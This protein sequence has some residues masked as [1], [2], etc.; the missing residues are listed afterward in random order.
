V[1]NPDLT[2]PDVGTAERG[3]DLHSPGTGRRSLLAALGLGGVVAAVGAARP[4]AAQDATTTT[5]AGSATTA[6]TT[7]APPK[8]PDQADLDVLGFAKQME[9]T[10]ADAFNTAFTKDK[11]DALAPDDVERELLNVLGAHHQA[12]AEAISALYGP[13]SPSSPSDEL[14]TALGT[15]KL[16]G[17]A[18]ADVRTAAAAIEEAA[19]DTH[20]EILGMLR[21]TNAATLIASI[22][23]VEARQAAVLGALAGQAYGADAPA[24]EDGT[25]SLTTDFLGAQ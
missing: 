9:L 12:Y 23:I 7:T 22:Q 19:V 25:S 24:E 21:S 16:A 13:G 1:D 20:L 4:A 5:T 3:G 6:T 2:V 10:I 8:A 18:L 15:D 14:K 17:A 11:L